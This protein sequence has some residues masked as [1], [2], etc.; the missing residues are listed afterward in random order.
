MG[1]T[2]FCATAAQIL[3]WISLSSVRSWRTATP[4]IWVNES[5][6]PFFN[7]STQ[8]PPQARTMISAGFSG[9]CAN[10][11]P[12][13]SADR[14]A[15]E[16]SAAAPPRSRRR[17]TLKSCLLSLVIVCLPVEVGAVSTRV[18]EQVAGIPAEM[19]RRPNPVLRMICRIMVEHPQRGT[20]KAVRLDRIDDALAFKD[21]VAHRGGQHRI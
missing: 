9:S 13:P 2:R 6:T 19:D 1:G 17:D 7:D 11:R 5:E 10:A 14:P 15:A 16:P 8:D 3:G 12:R 4:V 20:V 18:Y 21:R